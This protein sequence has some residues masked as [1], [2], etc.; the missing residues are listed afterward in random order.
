MLFLVS[1]FVNNDV[2]QGTVCFYSAFQQREITR[3]KEVSCHF[4]SFDN[5][6][7]LSGILYCQIFGRQAS[8]TVRNAIGCGI[9]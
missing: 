4:E 2:L 5:T 8:V 9:C 1:L 6:R 3:P 7:C